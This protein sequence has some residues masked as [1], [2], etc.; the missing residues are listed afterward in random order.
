MVTKSEIAATRKLIQSHFGSQMEAARR[1]QFHER[2]VR[3]WCQHGAPPHIFDTLQRLD[4]G[5]ISLAWA[6]ELMRRRRRRERG[7]ERHRTTSAARG[8]RSNN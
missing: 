5:T 2:T 3:W 4:R 1:L 8:I 6:R 7:R